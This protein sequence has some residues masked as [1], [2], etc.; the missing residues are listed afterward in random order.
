MPWLRHP[1]VTGMPAARWD[2]LLARLTLPLQT[3][4]EARLYTLRGRA[5][6]TPP[7]SGRRPLLTLEDRLLATILDQ[8]FWIPR[9][10]Y[11]TR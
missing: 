9:S 1:A 11:P 5:R 10:G 2:D 4:R 6:R 8:R 3:Q 7:G